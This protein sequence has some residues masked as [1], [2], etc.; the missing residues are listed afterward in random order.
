METGT[1]V[2]LNVG[3]F[4]PTLDPDGAIARRL[5]ECLVEGLTPHPERSEGPA[6]QSSNTA[7]EGPSL[8]SG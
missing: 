2:G 1:A 6:Q 4:N 7:R 5:V 8:R 3:I